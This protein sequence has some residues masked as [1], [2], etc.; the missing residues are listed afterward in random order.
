MDISD[1]RES[2]IWESIVK[3]AQLDG[4]IS[5]DESNLIRTILK[6]AKEYEA[7]LSRALEKAAIS[8]EDKIELINLRANILDTAYRAASADQK[9]TADELAIIQET[10]NI[11]HE[12][13]QQEGNMG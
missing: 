5:E 9:I 8:P 4:H 13:E 10:L 2:R 1:P 12:L 7:V 6:N 3:V 11:L